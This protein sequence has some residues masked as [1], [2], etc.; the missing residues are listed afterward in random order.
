MTREFDD[1]GTP[2]AVAVKQPSLFR[3]FLD[4]LIDL[5]RLPSW[6]NVTWMGAGLGAAAVIHRSDARVS[7]EFSDL[8]T[9]LFKPGAIIGGTPAM[10]GGAF[11]TYAMGRAFHSPGAV[12]LGSDLIRTQVIA[13]LLTVGVK[14]SVRRSR[15]DGGRF[16]FP[17]GH[18]AMS[19]GTAMVLQRHFGW[20]AGVPAYAVASYV[21]ASRVQMK[22]HYPSDVVFGAAVGIVA[23]RTVTFGRQKNM[24]LAPLPTLGGG[25]VSFIWREPS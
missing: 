3:P 7:R 17:S 18:S 24:T 14:Q 20:R 2:Q 6:Q 16:S 10:M 15:P 13:E 25:G 11:A 19:F 22:R 5:R 21:A 12:M 9:R 4:G 23:G 8:R 1:G